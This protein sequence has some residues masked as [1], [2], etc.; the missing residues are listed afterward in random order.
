MSEEFELDLA[1][2]FLDI[3]LLFELEIFDVEKLFKEILSLLWFKFFITGR[4]GV[5]FVLFSSKFNVFR[6][7]LYLTFSISL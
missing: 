5:S 6:F 4:D 3:T 2:S 1:L 7:P